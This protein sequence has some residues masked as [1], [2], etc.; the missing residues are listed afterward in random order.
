MPV[1]PARKAAGQRKAA[2]ASARGGNLP[3]LNASEITLSDGTKVG[4]TMQI[5]I[6]YM[7]CVFTKETV[8]LPPTIQIPVKIPPGMPTAQAEA[9]LAYLQA[10]PE[11]AKAAHAQVTS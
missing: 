9:L 4:R 6:R 8:S 11:A 10:N 5:Y 1:L 2:P 7:L 3:I